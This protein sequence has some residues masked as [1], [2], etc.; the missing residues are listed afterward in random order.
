MYLFFFPS[1][2]A[3][4]TKSF[5]FIPCLS[6]DRS[7]STH[8]CTLRVC[9]RFCVFLFEILPIPL[10]FCVRMWTMTTMCVFVA[11]TPCCEVFSITIWKK[12]VCERERERPRWCWMLLYKKWSVTECVC[13][14]IYICIYILEVFC[15]NVCEMMGKFS[16]AGRLWWG[17]GEDRGWKMRRGSQALVANR[18]PKSWQRWR[19]SDLETKK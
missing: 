6:P 2:F 9:V 13:I 7:F 1:L 5:E 19:K 4:Y 17:K 3:N 11:L 12:C 10:Y 16:F 18:F 14:F 15:M 8:M